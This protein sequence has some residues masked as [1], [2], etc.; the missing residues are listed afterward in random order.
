MIDKFVVV[1][2]IFPEDVID[3][4]RAHGLTR[5]YH[6]TEHPDCVN[7][8]YL[9][10]MRNGPVD[11]RPSGA[12]R[13]YR[14]KGDEGEE[15]ENFEWITHMINEVLRPQ[16]LKCPY[17]K[18]VGSF[19][20]WP[21]DVTYTPAWWHNDSF[22]NWTGILYLNKEMPDFPNQHIGGT[23]LL[24]NLETQELFR[25]EPKYNRLFLYRGFLFH[26]PQIGF[27][28]TID[29]CR[30]TFN[31]CVSNIALECLRMDGVPKY[32]APEVMHRI[33]CIADDNEKL[34]ALKNDPSFNF[35]RFRDCPPHEYD[36][37][38]VE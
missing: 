33:R 24:L 15:K 36:G 30:M 32:D 21:G 14:S 26:K 18:A 35:D 29:N 9:H 22:C 11:E 12:W 3:E 23:D 17:V 27:G 1:D 19:N 34:A 31:F 10:G 6:P 16:N 2:N 5:T 38:I 7:S 4:M 13:G 20:L 25:C 8:K 37:E 28:D